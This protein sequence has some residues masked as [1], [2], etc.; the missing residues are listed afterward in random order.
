M[1]IL[2]TVMVHQAAHTVCVLRER[3]AH[4][5]CGMNCGALMLCLHL[6]H[7]VYV[8]L[9]SLRLSWSPAQHL[10]ALLYHHVDHLQPV[11]PF[12][13]YKSPLSECECRQCLIG[14]NLTTSVNNTRGQPCLPCWELITYSRGGHKWKQACCFVFLL[15]NSPVEPLYGVR[16]L[17]TKPFIHVF[18]FLTLGGGAKWCRCECRDCHTCRPGLMLCHLGLEIAWCCLLCRGAVALLRRRECQLPASEWVLSC[19][20]AV[21]CCSKAEFWSQGALH[22]L[23]H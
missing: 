17:K 6:G 10:H 13:Y 19:L 12:Y 11:P 3:C 4:T 2:E 9:S 22:K 18:E 7:N 8:T 21:L 23:G 16:M 20:A 14:F 5:A 1:S 15:T